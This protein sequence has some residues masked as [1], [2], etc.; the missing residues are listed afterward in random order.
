MEDPFTVPLFW[1]PSFPQ[2]CLLGMCLP[3]PPSTLLCGLGILGALCEKEVTL[4]S[5]WR[6]GCVFRGSERHS[7]LG[8]TPTR[9]H[10]C[11]QLA[12]GSPRQ[13][14]L[15]YPWCGLA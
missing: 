4:G 15:L 2:D 6:S 9:G 11:H 14:C 3:P 10:G 1:T 8:V 5:S 12:E 7:G 13:F